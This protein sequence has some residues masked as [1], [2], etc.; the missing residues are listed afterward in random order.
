MKVTKVLT[1]NDWTKKM[2]YIHKRNTTQPIR[3]NDILAFAETWMD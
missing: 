1:T 2:W 3:K